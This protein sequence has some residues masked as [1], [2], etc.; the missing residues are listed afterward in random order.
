MT[1][2]AMSSKFPDHHIPFYKYLQIRHFIQ[3][4]TPTVAIHRDP[5]HFK[6]LCNSEGLQRHLISSIYAMLFSTH[7]LKEDKIVRQ[8]ETELQLDLISED[9][10][11]IYNHIHKGSINVSTQENRYKIFTKWYRTPDKIHKFYPNLPST[12]WR[13]NTADGTFLHIWWSCPL[14]QPYWTEIHSLISQ[15]TTYTPDFTPAQFLLHHTIA[16]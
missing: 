3:S 16:V 2:Q 4:C 6:H 12:C 7:K 10:G 11:H 13:C 8:W 1:H 15:I 5:S 9:W 14:I